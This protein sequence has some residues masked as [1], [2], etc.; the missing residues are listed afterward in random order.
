MIHHDSLIQS[1]HSYLSMYLPL[2]ISSE[3]H[4]CP[5]SIDFH[6]LASLFAIV[7]HTEH[8]EII[9]SWGYCILWPMSIPIQITSHLYPSI[10]EFNLIESTLYPIPALTSHNPSVR[11]FID[12]LPLPLIIVHAPSDDTSIIAYDMPLPV[13]DTIHHLSLEDAIAVQ[14]LANSAY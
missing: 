6:E 2:V 9:I 3:Y 7:V 12:P 4:F 8:D 14:V 5:R 13:G 10:R 11:I 1:K